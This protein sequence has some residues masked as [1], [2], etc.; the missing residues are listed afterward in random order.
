MAKFGS[1]EEI[2]DFMSDA[3]TA[4]SAQTHTE[5]IDVTVYDNTPEDFYFPAFH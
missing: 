3:R 2:A 1:A 5:E 4:L